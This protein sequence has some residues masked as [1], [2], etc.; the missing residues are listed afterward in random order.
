MVASWIIVSVLAL[1]GIGGSVWAFVRLRWLTPLPWI[2][3]VALSLTPLSVAVVVFTIINLL[4]A[5]PQYDLNGAKLAPTFGMLKRYGGYPL[6]PDPQTGVMTGWI[7][8]P[9]PALLMLPVAWIARS[10]TTAIVFGSSLNFL[11][12]MIPAAWLHVRITK[13]TGNSTRV[14]GAKWIAAL[15]FAAFVWMVCVHQT[16]LRAVVMIGP[17]GATL[18]LLACSLA[19][20]M[21]RPKTGWRA[22]A[23]IASSAG[24]AVLACWCKQSILPALV[25]VPV[26]LMLSEGWLEAVTYAIGLL[27]SGVVSAVVFVV[28]FGP[29]N[30][31]FHM[32]TLPA[33]HGWRGE[34]TTSHVWL[35][36]QAI[37]LLLNDVAPTLAVLGFALLIGHVVLPAR[38]TPAPM[39]ERWKQW[40]RVNPWTLL[41]MT[42]VALLPASLLGYLKVGGFLDNFALTHFFLMAAATV[43]LIE[44]YQRAP[45]SQAQGALVRTIVLATL[46]LFLFWR[47][48]VDFLKRHKAEQMFL[49][50][51]R[52]RSNQQEAVYDYAKREPGRAYFPWNTL[53]TLMA[54]GKYYHF[55]W[56]VVDRL[57][58]NLPPSRAQSVAHLPE[59]LELVAFGP[60]AQ[61]DFAM[62]LFEP[63]RA[64]DF[65]S[66]FVLY[67]ETLENVKDKP[68]LGK[69]S[70]R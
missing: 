30:M 32:V 8:G 64:R 66:G 11:Y 53:A 29:A 19:L 68:E 25:V 28:S 67:P 36:G 5:S 47:W 39:L 62:A 70:Q 26:Y 61:S 35:L 31:W 23:A 37:L 20:V 15:A 44:L 27:I 55:E 48:P 45:A 13:P 40:L 57:E 56:G 12:A 51:V 2:V 10:P 60:G 46:A 69:A 52:V 24:C 6:Y 43:Y 4:A 49:S 21:R 65:Q 17:D 41:P 38:P 33:R 9:V 42:A 63:P 1:A 58:A 54:E 18:G 3:R 34:S 7:Y 14:L 59:K 22:S 16:L 50:L